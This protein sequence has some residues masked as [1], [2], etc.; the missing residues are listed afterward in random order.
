MAPET[1]ELTLTS[2]TEDCIL[3]LVDFIESNT[4]YPIV[5]KI[6][7]RTLSYYTTPNGSKIEANIPPSYVLTN[8]PDVSVNP[9]LVIG[10][11]PMQLTVR[12]VSESTTV[13][14]N[15]SITDSN[16]I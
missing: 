15:G 13:S 9:H 6:G 5:G 16:S 8:S 4:I 1:I 14:S 7:T 2:H 10:V 12:S 11:I 3:L